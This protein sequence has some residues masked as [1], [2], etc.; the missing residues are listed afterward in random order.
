MSS[1]TPNEISQDNPQAFWNVWEVAGNVILALFFFRFLVQAGTGLMACFRISA[2]L[3]TCKL[4]LDVFFFL[5]RRRPKEVSFVP[6]DWAIAIVGTYC[7]LLFV[8]VPGSD[9]LLGTVVQ[10]FGFVLQVLSIL[11]LNR[12]FGIVAANRGI[13]TTGMYKYVRHP[14]YFAYVISYF[15]FIM[16]QPTVHNLT[17]YVC[18]TVFLYMRIVTEE[19]LLS[20]SEEYREYCNSTRCR[21]I[22]Y[23]M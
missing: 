7:S 21:L 3:L 20:K 9:N 5:T 1:T 19:R 2:L 15:G 14:L 16:N 12:S 13:K 10:T 22:P 17:I 8:T 23:V 18:M 11:S 4:S 6:Y